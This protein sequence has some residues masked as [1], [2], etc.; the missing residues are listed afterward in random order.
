MA[1]PVRVPHAERPT[2]DGLI[3][4]IRVGDETA[5]RV[6]F[7]KFHAPLVRLAFDY[8]KRRDVADEVVQDVFLRLW[9]RRARFEV[10]ESLRAYLCASVRNAALNKLR[11]DS[12]ERR[13][14]DRVGLEGIARDELTPR[15]ESTD[16][17]AHLSELDAALRT[18]VADL[19]PRCRETF[20]LSRQHALTHEEIGTV[21]GVSVKTV[22]V[23]IGRALAALRL[24]LA[25]HL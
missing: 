14:M 13:W 4:R 11:R 16:T 5:F 15:F 12:I 2:H 25:P 24:A 3:P 23:Q 7:E 19:P 8:L 18:A 9:E 22:Q 21:M 17:N 1:S 20:V 6:V 10:R